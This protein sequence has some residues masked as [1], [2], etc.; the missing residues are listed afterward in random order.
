MWTATVGLLALAQLASATTTTT[1]RPC[2]I[3]P[4]PFPRFFVLYTFDLCG[5]SSYPDQ[6]WRCRVGLDAYDVGRRNN[7]WTSTEI[8]HDALTGAEVGRITYGDVSTYQAC[9]IGTPV[10]DCVKEYDYLCEMGGSGTPADSGSPQTT[11]TGTDT[12]GKGGGKSNDTGCGCHSGPSTPSPAWL[13]LALAGLRRQS[14]R[15]RGRP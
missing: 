4:E 1:T 14:V 3:D 8:Y 5:T 11:D 12:D 15:L 9:W 2:V 7:G 10:L 6:A 13:L